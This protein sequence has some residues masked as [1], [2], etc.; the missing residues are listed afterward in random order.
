MAKARKGAITYREDD[1][2]STCQRLHFCTSVSE[3]R[4]EL[5]QEAYFCDDVEVRDLVNS[6]IKCAGVLLLWVDKLHDLLVVGVGVEAG[7]EGGVLIGDHADGNLYQV[8]FEHL[9]DYN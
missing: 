9:L 3:A 5:L 4:Q 1:A 6:G 8:D 2:W 7:D